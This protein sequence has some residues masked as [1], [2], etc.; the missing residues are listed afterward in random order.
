MVSRNSPSLSKSRFAAGLQCLKRLYF[1][2]FSRDLA[3]A[4]TPQQQAL[5]DGG[6]VV[7][8]LAR[9][10][11]GP[12]LLIAEPYFEHTVAVQHTKE[13]MENDEIRTLFEAAFSFEGINIRADI[14]TKN[15]DGS[16]DL[17]EVKSSTSYKPEHLPDI[18]IQQYVIEG[19]GYFV[20]KAGL[21]HIDNTYVYTGGD[22]DLERL[23]TVEDASAQAQTYASSEARGQLTEMWNVLGSSTEP[24]IATGPHCTKPYVCSFYRHCHPA[25]L[26]HAVNQL[27]SVSVKLLNNFKSA[28]I[29][30]ISD[31]PTGFQGLTDRQLRVRDAVVTGKPYE[32][33]DLQTALNDV[34]YPIH[35]LDFET[36]SPALPLYVGTRPYR[37]IPFQWSIHTLDS[38]GGLRHVEYLHNA[39]DDPRETLAL[40][41]LEALD[42]RGSIV[43]YTGFEEARIKELADALPKHR[44]SLLD[45]CGRIFDLHKV[46]SANY[47]H[48]EFHGSWS[49]KS[50]LPALIPNL[51][52]ADLDIKDGTLA[53]LSFGQMISPET[54]E[55]E[56]AQIRESLLAYCKRDT[57]AM[58]EIYRQLRTE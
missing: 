49:I 31:I 46:L 51:G 1:E 14:L 4:V 26:P 37:Q 7:G 36:I 3:D 16:L 44:G 10:R 22:Y 13:A 32:S 35:F 18:A 53:S 27:P 42:D 34:T 48:P 12:G 5:F 24:A 2:C 30:E 33:G 23:F 55:E 6:T 29:R 45:L 15:D 57:E 50:V 39:A 21:M 17:I 38:T 43:V 20:R 54:S 11:F 9:D 25:E 47:Y 58:V 8:E 28:G 41:M 56:K 19:L 40:E 52:Y